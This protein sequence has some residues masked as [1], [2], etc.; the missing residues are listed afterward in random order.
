[1]LLTTVGQKIYIITLERVGKI[2][3][4]TN[5]IIIIIIIIVII[6]STYLEST[7]TLKSEWVLLYCAAHAVFP[8]RSREN[9]F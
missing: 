5:A 7:V 1:M 8:K 4:N 9:S 3:D 6:N 2:Q